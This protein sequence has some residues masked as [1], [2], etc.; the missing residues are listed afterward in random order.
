MIYRLLYFVVLLLSRIPL[1]VGQFMGK[2]VG[3]VFAVIPS[4]RAA[5]SLDNIQKSFGDSMEGAEGRKL[6]RRVLI[7]FGEMFFEIPHIM[8]LNQRNL[9]KYVVFDQEEN[10]LRAMEKGKGV[11]VL[12]A[13]F[14]NWELMSAAVSIHFGP[15]AVLVRPIDFHP[16]DRLINELRSRFGT[17]TISKDRA[18]R[19]V[20]ATIKANKNVGILLDQNVDWYEGVFVDF[21]GR[22]ACTNKGLALLA[23]KTNAPVI[24]TF[25]VKQSDGRYRIIFGEEVKL[26]RT[27]DKTKDVEDNTALF[28]GVI[29]S[30][31]RK[32]P[33]QWFWFHQRWKTKPYCPL[34]QWKNSPQRH[35]G[36]I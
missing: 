8:R 23:L 30:Y 7:H 12:T 26:I 35:P 10:Y 15:G 19:R 4:K 25:S 33:D 31:I 17:E 34:P 6:N 32:Y 2:M 27:G 18:M 3:S 5:V 36:G 29:E 1:S 11:F 13:H 22:Q 24:P 9:S 14:G 20:M 28:T 21:L 16:L